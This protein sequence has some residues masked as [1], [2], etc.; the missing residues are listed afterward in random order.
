MKKTKYIFSLLLMAFLPFASVT[1]FAAPILIPLEVGYDD[2]NNGQ[3]DNGRGPVLIPSISIEGSELF[4]NTPC[5]GCV[6][7]IVDENDNV[8]YSVVIPTGATSLILP[9]YLQGNYEIQI[10]SG[11]YCFYGYIE[12]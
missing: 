7:R 8:C 3:G 11:I 10:V 4:F 1:V 12:L 6:L 9:S 5:D 2:P